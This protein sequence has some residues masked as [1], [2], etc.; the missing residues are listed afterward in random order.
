MRP[1][2][3]TVAPVIAALAISLA[4]ASSALAGSSN[5][6][7]VTTLPLDD[8][9]CFTSQYGGPTYCFDVDGQATIVANGQ[10]SKLTVNERI[11]TTVIE[12]GVVVAEVTEVSLLHSTYDEDGDGAVQEVVHS[13]AS[14]GSQ[15]CVF[16]TVLRIADFEVVVD[17][18]T[19]VNCS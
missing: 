13:R 8:A 10:G 4:G 12:D 11:R 9:W 3:R 7:G 1:L 15:T 2:F 6:A 17:H 18:V 16:G 5:A 19:S 14:W